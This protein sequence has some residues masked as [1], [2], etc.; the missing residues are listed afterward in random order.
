M[1]AEVM[2]ADPAEFNI[3]LLAFSDH[4]IFLLDLHV[5]LQYLILQLE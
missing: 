2:V 1:H 5:L 4:L 3:A